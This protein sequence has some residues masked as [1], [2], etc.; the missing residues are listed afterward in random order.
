MV[1]GMVWAF[2]KIK[3]ERSNPLGLLVDQQQL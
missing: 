3:A 2:L 1:G